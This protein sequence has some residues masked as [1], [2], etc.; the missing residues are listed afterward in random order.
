MSMGRSATSRS[1]RVR[2]ACVSVACVSLALCL[3]ACGSSGDSSKAGLAA[4]SSGIRPDGD[5]DNPADNDSDGERSPPA[6]DGKDD[7][8]DTDN[9][10]ATANSYDFPD[11][12]DKFVL[13][14][15]RPA[16]S[17]EASLLTGIVK[18][19]YVLAADGEV[20]QA[21]SLLPPG[22]AEEY[23]RTNRPAYLSEGDTTCQAI[24]LGMFAHFS[25]QLAEPIRVVAVR[26]KGTTA[27]VVI[28]SKV[29]PA[30]SVTLG[31][32]GGVWRIQ[33]DPLGLPLP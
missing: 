2:L 21:C 15:G 12:D 31:R 28:G 5:A 17:A 1:L 22:T 24:M 10:R 30:S 8:G 11:E 4:T 13:D 25:A 3:V 26:I 29:M 7:D 20:A 19:Y 33:E 32:Q 14:Y 6:P 9:D 18:H 27:R 16:T 23:A